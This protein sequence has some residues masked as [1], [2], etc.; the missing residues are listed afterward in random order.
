MMVPA[1]CSK[2]M[3]WLVGF[4]MKDNPR[5]VGPHCFV[6]KINLLS[7]DLKKNFDEIKLL[8][9]I[10]WVYVRNSKDRLKTH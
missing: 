5:L 4:M 10:I 6:H 7:N 9:S 8:N 2:K 1:I 3:V